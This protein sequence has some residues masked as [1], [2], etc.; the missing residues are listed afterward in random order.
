MF[1]IV[2]FVLMAWTV[3]GFN[4]V[5]KDSSVEGCRY[6]YL[7]VGSNKGM[8]VRFLFESDKYPQ[9]QYSK[10]IFDKFFMANRH[11]SDICAFGFEP[12]EA[13][14]TRLD[15]LTAHLTKNG[16]RAYFYHGAVSNETSTATFYGNPKLQNSAVGFTGMDRANFTTKFTVNT[17]NLSEFI[18]RKIATRNIPPPLFPN[19][20]PPTVVMKMDIEGYESI[21]LPQMLASKALCELDVL[22]IEYHEDRIPSMKGFQNKITQ[23]LKAA[24]DSGCKVK[25]FNFDD[26]SYYLDTP[27]GR[28]ELN[29]KE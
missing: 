21:V 10:R 23:Q 19:D 24:Q 11:R 15:H 29:I 1:G 14:V 16:F 5:D 12:N 6:V 18:E 26:E 2:C 20:P 4:F 27:E 22:T 3:H 28:A 8:H 13:H 9:N 25:V 7:D 17:I